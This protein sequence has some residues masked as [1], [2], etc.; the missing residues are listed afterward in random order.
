MTAFADKRKSNFKTNSEIFTLYKYTSLTI[1]AQTRALMKRLNDYVDQ[2]SKRTATF[3]HLRLGYFVTNPRS[4]LHH[5]L[6]FDKK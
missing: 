5:M 4:I 3:P 1:S 6:S 2:P